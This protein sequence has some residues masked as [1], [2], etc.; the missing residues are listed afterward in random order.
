MQLAALIAAAASFAWLAFLIHISRATDK[1]RRR[2]R[3]ALTA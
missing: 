1:P 3:A 2:K